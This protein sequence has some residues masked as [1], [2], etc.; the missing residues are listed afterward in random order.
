MTTSLFSHSFFSPQCKEAHK[1]IL[2]KH[3]VAPLPTILLPLAVQFPLFITLVYVLRSASASTLSPLS[4]EILPWLETSIVEP[5]S[6]GMLPIGVGLLMWVNTDLMRR[7][8][9][10]KDELF[11]YETKASSDE[12]DG[13]VK[14]VE[15]V[16]KEGAKRMVEVETKK[17]WRER[18]QGNLFKGF[19]VGFAAISMFAPAVRFLLSPFPFTL[20]PSFFSFRYL[21]RSSSKPRL[22]DKPAFWVLV[23]L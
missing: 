19:A 17:G 7:A 10:Q 18:V 13:M 15:V 14:T 12:E 6:T 3:S 21:K 2:D 22:T 11:P 9:L 23:S 4:G 16:D 5:D 8:R 1:A 20:L